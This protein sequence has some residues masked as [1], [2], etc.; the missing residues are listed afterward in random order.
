[1]SSFSKSAVDIP[2]ICSSLN[3]LC[4]SFGSIVS[5]P[6]LLGSYQSSFGSIWSRYLSISEAIQAIQSMAW[7][8]IH[9][10]IPGSVWGN[11][12]VLNTSIQR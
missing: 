7:S 9:L 1:M 5:G 4:S 10:S 12:F 2:R 6:R 8:Y 11:D 3:K